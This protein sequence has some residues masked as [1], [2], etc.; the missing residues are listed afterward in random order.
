M[1]EKE[2]LKKLVQL[3]LEKNNW[4]EG[5]GN[6]MFIF[7]S[8][9]GFP[10]CFFIDELKKQ[11][12]KITKEDIF[13]IIVA[14]QHKKTEHKVLSGIGEERL[15]EYQKYNKNQLIKFWETEELDL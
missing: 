9:K 7:E 4:C 14:Y 15:K 2:L 11:N 6:R 13:R 5:L 8:E 1:N 12:P 3:T 10:A